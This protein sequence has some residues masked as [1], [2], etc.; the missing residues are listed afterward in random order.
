M[1]L[2]VKWFYILLLIINTWMLMGLILFKKREGCS[3]LPLHLTGS[4]KITALLA[5]NSLSLKQINKC[6]HH[7]LFVLWVIYLYLCY[8]MAHCT[9]DI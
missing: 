2:A 4:G 9:L 5:R 1:S 6:S 8:F 3:L 7:L